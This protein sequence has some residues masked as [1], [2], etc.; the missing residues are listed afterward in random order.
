[1]KV[2]SDKLTRADLY[3]A[4]PGP[5][6]YLEATEIRGARVR[7]RGWTVRLEALR[8][9][10]RFRNS[11]QYGAEST[12]A[13]TWDEHGEW[14]AALFAIDPDARIAVYDGRAEFERV[15]KG[16]Y[17]RGQRMIGPRS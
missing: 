5:S 4:L 16:E 2:Y 11:G 8:G 3:G 1:M 15:T 14:M 9:A 7:S 6:L 10:G 12:R 17:G 13:A